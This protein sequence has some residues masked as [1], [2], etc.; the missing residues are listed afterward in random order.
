MDPIKPKQ[1]LMKKPDFKKEKL[2]DGFIKL[3]LAALYGQITGSYTTE[4]DE[5][6]WNRDIFLPLRD[7][8]RNGNGHIYNINVGGL[9]HTDVEDLTRRLQ[10][11]MRVPPRYFSDGHPIGI[12]SRRI[13]NTDGSMDL[14]S[15]D[16]V[17][18]QTSPSEFL[19]GEQ[20]MY[21]A[22]TTMLLHPP[23]KKKTFIG[24]VKQFFLDIYKKWK[25]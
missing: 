10:E 7:E 18:N 23:R 20:M 21:K 3:G 22:S 19:G 13:Q 2:G 24:K 1:L 15:Y 14:L 9:D 16:L 11:T 17:S 4:V 8:G 5:V 12:T 6:V 25:I